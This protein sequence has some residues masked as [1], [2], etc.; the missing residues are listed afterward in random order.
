[1]LLGPPVMCLASS[2]PLTPS[3]GMWHHNQSHTGCT[4]T[5]HTL[6]APQPVTRSLHHNHSHT[7]CTTTLHTL[8]APQPVTRSLHH[9]HSHAGC[10]T[11]ESH[12]FARHQQ[13]QKCFMGHPRDRTESTSTSCHFVHTS[14]AACVTLWAHPPLTCESWGHV[15]SLYGWFPT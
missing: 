3:P 4:T 10:T 11:R 6:T 13:T 12:Q 14:G 9:N 7:G 2:V 15:D 8:T 5:L 1:M